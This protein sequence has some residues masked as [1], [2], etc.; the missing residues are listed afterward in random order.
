MPEERR[1]IACLD[2]A[3][4]D[5][6]VEVGS[7]VERTFGSHQDVEW[8][9][10]TDGTL[11]LLQSRPVTTEVRGV[12]QGPIYGPGPVAETFPLDRAEDADLHVPSQP[13][14]DGHLRP[15]VTAPSPYP[16]DP[17]TCS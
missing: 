13:L 8:A 2:R 12:P 7:R 4:L 6:L 9:I 14:H 10:G 17:V 3:A 1:A 16:L 5:A 15:D 11:W